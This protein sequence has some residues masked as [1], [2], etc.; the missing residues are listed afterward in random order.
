MFCLLQVYWCLQSSSLLY[1]YIC[2]PLSSQM[3]NPFNLSLYSRTIMT[4]LA[5]NYAFYLAIFIALSLFLTYI[6]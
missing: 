2:F 6:V 3:V 5:L 4:D 1:S